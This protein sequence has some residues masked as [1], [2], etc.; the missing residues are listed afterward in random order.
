MQ[1]AGNLALVA[2]YAAGFNMN[3]YTGMM[4]PIFYILL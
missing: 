3:S 2:F 4:Q 1:I